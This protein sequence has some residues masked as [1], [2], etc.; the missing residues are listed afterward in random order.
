[1]KRFFCALFLVLGLASRGSAQPGPPVP[2][3]TT[4]PV[5][6]VA[7]LPAASSMTGRT[8][9]VW[10]GATGGTCTA[11]GGGY[12]NLCQ[13]NGAS[14]IT[15]SGGGS[16]PEGRTLTATAP[17]TGGGDLTANRAFACPTCEITT[18]KGAANGYAGLDV[19][20]V[21]LSSQG[22]T[23]NAFTKFTGP[24]TTEKTFT[25]PDASG[26]LGYFSGTPGTG[27]VTK[28]DATGLVTASATSTG[29]T[30]EYR[31]SGFADLDAWKTQYTSDGSPVSRLVIE[32]TRDCTGATCEIPANVTVVKQGNGLIDLKGHN[33]VVNGPL[34]VPSGAQL[35]TDSV[36]G[37]SVSVN[38]NT[39]VP[40]ITP[41]MFSP[42]PFDG[43]TD[44]T[45]AVNLAIAAAGTSANTVLRLL[46]NNIYAVDQFAAASNLQVEA[47]GATLLHNGSNKALLY[48]SPASPP[49]VNSML[50]FSWHGGVLKAKQ[51][52]INPTTAVLYMQQAQYC[53]ISEVI[54]QAGSALNGAPV[55]RYATYGIQ[56]VGKNGSGS[57]YDMFDHVT[58]IGANSHGI[59]IDGWDT[60]TNFANNLDFFGV[61]S[62]YNGG[63]GLRADGGQVN[64]FFGGDIEQNV[65]Y[66]VNMMARAKSYNFF[67][68]WVEA[69][70]GGG[71]NDNFATDSSQSNNGSSTFIGYSSATPAT[72]N[73]SYWKNFEIF[74]NTIYG[75]TPKF[76]T[77]AQFNRDSNGQNA[78]TWG[79]EG[80]AQP[81]G[82]FTLSTLGG[83]VDYGIGG[84]TAPDA[85]FGRVAADAVGPG[86]G[87]E[88]NL[89]QNLNTIR[90]GRRTAV[91]SA[92]PLTLSSGNIHEITGVTEI[93]TITATGNTGRLIVLH[94]ASALT[95]G[96][97]AGG[98]NI[99]L[100][101]AVNYS[102]AADDVL[103]LFCDGTNWIE[104]AR[105][106]AGGFAN[107]SGLTVI[108]ANGQRTTTTFN[109][110]SSGTIPNAATYTFTGLIPA[111]VEGQGVTCRVT[112]A[113]TGAAKFD[114]GVGG[115]TDRFCKGVAAALNTTCNLGTNPGTSTGPLDYHTATDVVL[116]GYAVDGTTPA[117]F[118]GGVVE[119][120]AHY[121]TLDAPT[122]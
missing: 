85:R 31:A 26:T 72:A 65:S 6:T 1:M 70:N 122:S 79:I 120:V 115:A 52:A 59:F 54:V 10:D 9:M 83:E 2:T 36:G 100:A 92:S 111:G 99:K 12:R 39:A 45:Q 119:C 16:V 107:A 69:N 7:T 67:G 35:F 112:T 40:E 5:F 44:N 42:G 18:R 101:G 110:A 13:S 33:V 14:W 97:L 77:S 46:P 30:S 34:D 21:V 48:V 17:L 76:R 103:V 118:T 88:L 24:T 102:A 108:G 87:D 56:L 113:V 19:G 90:F 41:N 25:L 60:S 89:Q 20:G 96:H 32:G 63:E 15:L 8:V 57:Y 4:I 82:V 51:S 78:L 95:V 61:R 23:G 64:N 29:Y 62:Q 49:A 109:R 104:I 73:Q 55:S 3:A 27:F 98:G 47:Q 28:S 81:Q 114:V 58:V 11:G 80:E 43:A 50:R 91:A 121:L 68:T 66:G 71:S 22:G 117:N 75:N 94:F 53:K 86:S 106:S 93:D 74:N 38:G 37:G 116:T 84:S 105:R